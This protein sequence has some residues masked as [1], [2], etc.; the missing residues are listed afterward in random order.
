[1]PTRWPPHEKTDAAKKLRFHFVFIQKQASNATVGFKKK[2]EM[3][4]SHAALI[5]FCKHRFLKGLPASVIVK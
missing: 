5:S 1:M 4:P 2:K 3:V